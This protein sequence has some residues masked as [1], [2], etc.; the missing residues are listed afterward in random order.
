V[1]GEDGVDDLRDDGVVVADDAG[2]ETDSYDDAAHAPLAGARFERDGFRY[3]SSFASPVAYRDGNE[4][5]DAALMEVNGGKGGKKKAGAGAPSPDGLT[6]WGEFGPI[7]DIVLVD[8]SKG[9]LGWSHWEQRDGRPVAVYQF[10]IPKAVS[11]YTLVFND[12]RLGEMIGGS[13]G[14][15]GNGASS[16]REMD[17][18]QGMVRVVT[19][20]HGTL[21]VDPETGTVLR[22]AME[23]DIPG[24]VALQRAAM[25]VEYAP[26][27]IGD[28]EYICPWHSVTISAITGQYRATPTSALE[29]VVDFRLNDVRFEN[30]RR[31]GSEIKLLLSAQADT[32]AASSRDVASNGTTDVGAKSAAALQEAPGTA[33]NAGS[34]SA[35]ESEKEAG[36][37]SAVAGTE[38]PGSAVSGAAVAGSGVSEADEEVILRD[39]AEMPG[40]RVGDD[41]TVKPA[42]KS[43]ADKSFT[44]QVATRL[45]DMGVIV[46]DK[47]DRP[48]TDLKPE[49][50]AIYD[51]GR[52]QKVAEFHHTNAE[53]VSQEVTA[54]AADSAAGDGAYTNAPVN[55]QQAADM[56]DLMVLLLDES[57]LPFNDL[58]RARGEVE[59]FL[60]SVRSGTRLA[61]YAVGEHGFRTIQDVTTNRAVLEARLKVWVPNAAGVSQAQEQDTRNRQ[62]FDYVR[63]ASDLQY[64]NGNQMDSP[65][66]PGDIAPDP[67][68]RKL[69]DDPLGQA[70]L[71]LAAVAR[72]FAPVTGHKAVVWI[73]GDNALVDWRDQEVREDRSVEDRTAAI[74]HTM[75]ALNEAHTALYIVD[76]SDLGTG[77]ATVDPGLA[78]PAVELSPVA[79]TPPGSTR[80]PETTAGRMSAALQHDSRGIQAP[81]RQLAES[82]GGR[83]FNKGSD[84]TATLKTI[85]QDE[86]ALYA[87]GFY[88]DTPADGKFHTLRLVVQGR[89]DLRLRYRSG[90]LYDAEASTTKER[91]QRAVWSP[92]DLSGITLRAEAIHADKAV[93]GD[94][95]VRLRI[96]FT[97]L[98]LQQRGGHWADDLYIFLAQRDDAAQKAQVTGD[99]LRLSLKQ[100]TY[101]TGM[102]AGIPYQHELTVKSAAKDSSVRVIV[103]DGNSGKMGSVTVPARAFVD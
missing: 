26:V 72:H 48:V 25:M 66:A 94:S 78:N 63:R 103:V 69:G 97:G 92:Q 43:L 75:E 3:R 23:A 36:G 8:A 74:H 21:A 5:R 47:H 53:A 71:S 4:I 82:T 64:V 15:G 32:P 81:V 85:A 2:E 89:K 86:T 14:G 54:A 51:N 11:H 96:G 80:S 45:V 28:A 102:P 68:L 70:L 50:I 24:S 87:M 39:V 31:F 83:A 60:E 33:G 13:Y 58:N 40:M 52:L 79:S 17:P 57:H 30:Y 67:Q 34:A 90:Y 35:E 41:A 77:A 37:S 93:N 100:A 42:E 49:E 88:P 73:S 27:R 44:L 9:K 55:A 91:L 95:L 7:L 10:S 84:L 1:L 22:A 38:A 62:Q 76:A 16:S 12:S 29:N 65:D 20:Y 59:Q 99:T 19:A 46:T 56:P 101:E 98:D 18:G 61:L 6:S